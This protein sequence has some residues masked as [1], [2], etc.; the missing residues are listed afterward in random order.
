MPGFLTD[1]CSGMVHYTG[2]WRVL[3]GYQAWET[4]QRGLVH[5]AREGVGP[6][7]WH[8]YAHSKLEAI[9]LKLSTFS[10]PKRT[11]ALFHV[12]D[13]HNTQYDT[14]QTCVVRYYSIRVRGM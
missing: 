8:Q 11:G 13:T 4:A 7:P 5:G 12:S 10:L 6:C 14:D 2:S 1:I 9:D 3:H